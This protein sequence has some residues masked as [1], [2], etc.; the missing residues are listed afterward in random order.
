M[1]SAQGGGS[2]WH[3]DPTGMHQFRYFDTRWTDQVS[4]NGVQSLAPMPPP[5]PPPVPYPPQRKKNSKVAWF[6]AGG[7][8]VVVAAIVIGVAASSG[9]S[10]SSHNSGGG[11]NSFCEDFAGQWDIVEHGVITGEAVVIDAQSNPGFTGAGVDDLNA[12]TQGA[13]DAGVLNNEAPSSLKTQISGISKYLL[14]VVKVAHGDASAVDQIPNDNTY[15]E[16]SASL[17]ASVPL[18]ICQNHSGN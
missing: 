15:L 5:A 3:P 7:A 12:V 11:L 14:I 17:S 6:I 4:D 13:Q 18:T 1:T 8:A 9:G 2:G 16:D 10:G